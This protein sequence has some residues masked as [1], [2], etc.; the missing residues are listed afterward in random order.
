MGLLE[1]GCGDFGGID[2]DAICAFSIM[3][4]PLICFLVVGEEGMLSGNHVFAFARVQPTIVQVYAFVCQNSCNACSEPGG[5]DSGERGG[6]LTYMST[7]LLSLPTITR[8]FPLSK[9]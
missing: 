9:V 1:Y 2:E 4:G 5:K 3:Y 8:G 6:E 7:S